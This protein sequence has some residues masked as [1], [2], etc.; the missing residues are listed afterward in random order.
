MSTKSHNGKNNFL[1]QTWNSFHQDL[2]SISEDQ[3]V[4][5]FQNLFFF[6]FCQKFAIR[7]LWM[8]DKF[9]TSKPLCSWEKN[10]IGS[11]VF[12]QNNSVRL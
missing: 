3:F 1:S 10:K 6:F 4:Q 8:L 9:S 12:S 7:K 11:F 2:V 5:D